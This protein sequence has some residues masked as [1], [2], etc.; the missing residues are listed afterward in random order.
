MATYSFHLPFY[1]TALRKEDVAAALG[2]LAPISSRYG[3]SHW[4]VY[5]GSDDQYKFT[6][7]VDFSEKT[8]FKAFWNGPEAIDF[9]AAM[10]GAYQNPVLYYQHTVVEQGEAVTA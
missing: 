1:A 5:Q 10:S 9:R 6:L 2:Q 7:I 8:A 3:A 4:A